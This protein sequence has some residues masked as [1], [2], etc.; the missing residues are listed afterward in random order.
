MSKQLSFTDLEQS[1]KINKMIIRP[2]RFKSILAPIILIAFFH[3]YSPTVLAKCIAYDITNIQLPD[4]KFNFNSIPINGKIGSEIVTPEQVIYECSENYY[5]QIQDRGGRPEI[6]GRQIYSTS[7]PGIGYAV[8]LEPTNF[9]GGLVYWSPFT[10]CN[11]STNPFKFKAK[12]RFQLYKTGPV[13][14]ASNTSIGSRWSNSFFQLLETNN[15]GYLY[16]TNVFYSSN[17]FTLTVY[18]CSLQS[19]TITN[20]NLPQIS[21]LDLPSINS[22]T[23]DTPFSIT[24][25][26]PTTTKLSITFTDNNK[27]GQT[28]SILTPAAGSTAKGV[29]VQ[30]QYN[31]NRVNFGPDSSEPGTTNQI[32]LN[33]NL[34]GIQTFPFSAAYIRTGTVTAGTLSTTATFTLSYQ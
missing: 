2:R 12:L 21:I 13:S 28:G 1:A 20:I 4:L 6:S 30:L 15:N 22:I 32:T 5:R 16:A 7:T 11:E 26:C 23:G 8:A 18:S 27:I 24:I 25:K 10:T 3:F 29:G 31:G 14:S 33:S 17:P 34:T 19:S 9:C